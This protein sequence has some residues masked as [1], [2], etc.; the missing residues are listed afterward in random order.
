MGDALIK[1]KNISVAFKDKVVLD[2]LS[3]T[4]SKGEIIGLAAPNGTGKTTLFNVMANFLK[5][6]NGEVTFNDK[7]GFNTE[8]DKLYIHKHMSTFPDQDDLFDELS[9]VDHLKLYGNMWKGTTKHL[10]D[11]IERLKMDDYVKRKVG[12]YSLG[13]R[14]RLCFAMMAAA[15]TPV[16]LMDEVMNG[17]DFSNV[18]L[19]S[20]YLL[21]MKKEEKLIFV[22]SHLLENLDLYADRV[23]FLKEGKIVQQQMLNEKNESYIKI[24]INTDEYEQLRYA[25]PDDHIYIAKRLLCIPLADMSIQEQI[26]W[27]ERLLVFN[28]EELTIGA[29]GTVEYYEKHYHSND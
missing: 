28:D 20:E 3:L 17:L 24:A 27:I 16:M 29:L 8:K 23:L 5:P 11:I 21:D 10:P 12:T 7:Y 15:D 26:K 25:L 13:M 1:L 19:I 22:S 6:T 4:A 14:Q 2:N 18:A 9:G